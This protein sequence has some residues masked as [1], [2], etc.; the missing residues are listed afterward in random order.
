[1]TTEIETRCA[2][3][4]KELRRKKGF[5]LEEFERHSNGAIKAV[6]LGSYE[7]GTRAISLARIS[8][9]AELY[10]VPLEYFFT[11]AAP[12]TH[13]D[14]DRFIFDLR[15]MRK[16]ENADETIEPVKRFIIRICSL[17]QDWNGEV[18]SLRL[19]DGDLLSLLTELGREELHSQLRLAGLLFGSEVS[20]KRSL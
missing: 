12:V 20:G 11:S 18:I 19:S 9:L 7:R 4:L 14:G 15:K 8:Q 5:T 1:M 6:V 16:I 2:G 10:E 17:R 13:I 3:L